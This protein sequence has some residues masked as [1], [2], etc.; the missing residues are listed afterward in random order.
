[1]HYRRNGTALEMAAF[2]FLTIAVLQQHD[3]RLV[4]RQIFRC[5]PG[6]GGDNDL[7]SDLCSSG[8]G[9]IQQDFS[10]SGRALNLEYEV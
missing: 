3:L 6:V 7:I 4:T 9:S 2:L 5:Q 8:G 10:R 1:M